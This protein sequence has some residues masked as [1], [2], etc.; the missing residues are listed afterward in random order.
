MVSKQWRNASSK[1]PN[2][3]TTF[4][5]F[6]FSHPQNLSIE[7]YWN[8]LKQRLKKTL[9]NYEKSDNFMDA[10]VGYF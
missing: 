10:L 7:T 4:L 1:S 3:C 8:W 6:A 5:N 2:I 9:H